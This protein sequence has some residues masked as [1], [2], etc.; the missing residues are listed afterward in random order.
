MTESLEEKITEISMES[1]EA[2]NVDLDNDGWVPIFVSE[3]FPSSNQIENLIFR[4]LVKAEYK[5]VEF[6]EFNR[7][8]KWFF[9]S[10]EGEMTSNQKN[11]FSLIALL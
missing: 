10:K 5:V 6:V 2:D 4:Q 9:M 3:M 1:I 7:D 11:Y 8:G